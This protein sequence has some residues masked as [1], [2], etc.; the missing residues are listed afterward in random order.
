[1]HRVHLQEEEVASSS[2]ERQLNVVER[3]L[4]LTSRML[5]LDGK[6]QEM[7]RRCFD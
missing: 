5:K 3:L 1:M 6:G 4:F 7:R 2:D